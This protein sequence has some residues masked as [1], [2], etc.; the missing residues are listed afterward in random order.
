MKKST[1]ESVVIQVAQRARP[2]I[3]VVVITRNEADNITDCL[4]GVRWADEIIVVDSG[5]TD[6]T[7]ELARQQD[8]R[9]I[10]IDWAGFGAAKQRG[11]DEARG[12]WVLSIDADERV[13]PALA[14]EIQRAVCDEQYAGYEMP[15][16]TSFV[17]VWVRHSGWYPD[18]VLRLFCKDCG[19]FSQALV[20]EGV[21]VDGA[22]G[23]LT[24]DLLHYSY[25]SLTDYL[26]RLNRYT[27]LAAQELHD[28]GVRAALW[29]P[30]LKPP[31]IFLK[32]YLLKAGFLD[33]WTGLQIAF[34][35]AVYVFVKYA[36]LRDLWR[37]A[38]GER[39]SPPVQ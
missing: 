18:F 32:R 39:Q 5:S 24:H 26:Q 17:G 19:R 3:S 23:R 9:V 8:A 34:L 11:V 38:A 6:R 28:R 33:G 36:K 1:P 13:T 16:L 2:P 27:T 30:L 14:E 4:E 31:A 21:T 35:S 37:G 10:D 15:R 7:R 22:V 12:P 20:H 29:Q 25:R